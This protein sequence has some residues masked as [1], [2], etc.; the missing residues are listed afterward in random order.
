MFLWESHNNLHLGSTT[1][2]DA[3]QGAG[4]IISSLDSTS[5]DNLHLGLPSVLNSTSSAEKKDTLNKQGKKSCL[6]L[7]LTVSNR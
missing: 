5:H 2:F 7:L 3:P 1:V 6:V 4:T